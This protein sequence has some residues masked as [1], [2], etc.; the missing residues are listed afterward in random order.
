MGYYADASPNCPTLLNFH[1]NAQHLSGLVPVTR[2]YG[3]NGV[4]YLTIAYRGYSGSTGKPSEE[5]LRKDAEAAYQFL[6][7]EGARPDTIVASGFSLGSSIALGIAADHPVSA[8]VLGAPFE[9]G[10]RLGQDMLP[11]L[12]VGLVAG[13]TFRSDRLAPQVKAP[14]L[15]IH[16]DQDEII[17]PAHSEDLAARFPVPA[18]RIVNEGR[19]HNTLLDPTYEG[20]VNAFLAPLFPDCPYLQEPL[21]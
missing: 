6:L 13:D 9:S 3:E 19:R 17:P 11:I 10:T 20:Q 18:T 4:G 14:V 21:Q 5:G 8:V 2:R 12:P 15:I 16:G 7:S 1:G